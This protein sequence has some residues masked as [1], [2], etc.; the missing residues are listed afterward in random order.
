MSFIYTSSQSPIFIN[1]TGVS[2]RRNQ[3]E[4]VLG[5]FFLLLNKFKIKSWKLIA[6]RFRYS[7]P[8]VNSKLGNYSFTQCKAVV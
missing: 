2:N 3:N 8:T 6:I 7:A 4:G 1:T 5:V